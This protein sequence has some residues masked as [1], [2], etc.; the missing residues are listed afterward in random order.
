VEPVKR[1]V[2]KTI[3]VVEKPA[4]P[5]DTKSSALRAPEKPA[6]GPA[7]IAKTAGSAPPV[8]ER[9]TEEGSASAS[10]PVVIARNPTPAPE[11][12]L[13][14]MSSPPVIEPV[15][16]RAQVGKPP[17]RAIALVPPR[18]PEE[19]G[20]GREATTSSSKISVARSEAAAPAKPQPASPSSSQE[21]S[22]ETPA[23][24]QLALL[25]KPEPPT[26]EKKPLARAPRP[27]EGF[28]IQIAFNDKQKAQS[29]AEKM[30]QRG[31]AVSIT[32]EGSG[33]ALRVRLGNF[34]IRDDAERQ[35]RSFKQE[36]LSGIVINLPQAFRPEARASAP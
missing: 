28:V 29:W 34:T 9:E 36:G 11:T 30:E 35:L 20:L 10:E 32:E 6:A 1:Q 4:L 19:S 33:G 3:E 17:E 5:L 16:S 15:K 12:T 8:K 22:R 23:V 18:P 26:L 7:A 24:E 14:S 31:Y 13:K 21:K 27:L 2:E 25:R